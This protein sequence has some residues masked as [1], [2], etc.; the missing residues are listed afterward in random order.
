MVS[1]FSSS[2]GFFVPYKHVC[3]CLLIA[4]RFFTDWIRSAQ[5]RIAVTKESWFASVFLPDEMTV[6][7]APRKSEQA[8]Y[9]LVFC[10]RQEE[11]RKNA[12]CSQLLL[13]GVGVEKLRDRNVFLA[14]SIAA[15]EFFLSHLN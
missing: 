8:N 15:G 3:D 5:A 6:E 7:D 12:V 1:S 9:P 13:T 11:T 10:P 2:F 4:T 14:A